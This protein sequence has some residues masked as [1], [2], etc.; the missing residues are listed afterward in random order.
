MLHSP[1]HPSRPPWLLALPELTRSNA[2]PP[3]CKTR[4]SVDMR[5]G[6]PSEAKIQVAHYRFPPDGDSPSFGLAPT[7]GPRFSCLDMPGVGACFCRYHP[8]RA[9]CHVHVLHVCSSSC[10]LDSSR[11]SL[12]LLLLDWTS[13]AVYKNS[14]TRQLQR[15]SQP[16]ARNK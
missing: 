7:C 14:E 5:H 2:M 10:S 3:S 12:F 4:F 16:P 13:A 1:P 6:A 15:L 8:L 9:R 11:R